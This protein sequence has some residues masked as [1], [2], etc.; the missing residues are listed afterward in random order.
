M[1]S[2]SDFMN[3]Y[4]RKET[5]KRFIILANITEINDESIKLI[6]R[7]VVDKFYWYFWNNVTV[8]LEHI[9]KNHECKIERIG[10]LSYIFIHI[11]D[12]LNPLY[13]EWVPYISYD[14]SKIY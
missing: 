11:T 2:T 6:K 12:K 9:V 1:E 13:D 8:F 5:L 10:M 3:E 4:E 7:L 14:S